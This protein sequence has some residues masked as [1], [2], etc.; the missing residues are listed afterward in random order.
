M[1]AL[2][3]EGLTRPV[4]V[5]LEP[6]AVS[7]ATLQELIEMGPSGSTAVA[8]SEQPGFP[9]PIYPT[10][11]STPRWIVAEVREWL[12]RNAS[13]V[14]T[15]ARKYHPPKSRRSPSTTEPVEVT[16]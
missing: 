15:G 13:R 16:Q 3:K 11:S 4:L 12:A 7:M 6:I 8:L 2:T 1:T 5:Q 14:S 10:G 9:S